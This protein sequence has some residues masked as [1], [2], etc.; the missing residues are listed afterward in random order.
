MSRRAR[1]GAN[2]ELIIDAGDPFGLTRDLLGLLLLLCVLDP[3]LERHHTGSCVD[4]DL[5]PLHVSVEEV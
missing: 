3:S 5:M 2:G 1:G 4:V